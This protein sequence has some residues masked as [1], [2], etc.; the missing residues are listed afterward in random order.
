MD[1]FDEDYFLSPDEQYKRDR[2]DRLKR[3][4]EE[5]NE[6]RKQRQFLEIQSKKDVSALWEPK[7]EKTKDEKSYE[8]EDEDF[9]DNLDEF[10]DCDNIEDSFEDDFQSDNEK[11]EHVLEIEE[12]SNRKSLMEATDGLNQKHLTAILSFINREKEPKNIKRIMK[13]KYDPQNLKYMRPLFF[14]KLKPLF[15][16]REQRSNDYEDTQELKSIIDEIGIYKVDNDTITLNGA[17]NSSRYRNRSC[18][19]KYH[20]LPERQ[21]ERIKAFLDT[22]YNMSEISAVFHRLSYPEDYQFLLKADDVIPSFHPNSGNSSDLVV[23]V[24]E[25][26]YCEVDLNDFETWPLYDSDDVDIDVE[27]E[28]N[29]QKILNDLKE[30]IGKC[31]GLTRIDVGLSI[32]YSQISKASSFEIR[33]ID[34][35]IKLNYFPRVSVCIFKNHYPFIRFNRACASITYMVLKIV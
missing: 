17:V 28:V 4:E 21:S 22:T 2:Q 3:I 32:P 9:E 33:L 12:N 31:A 29:F 34:M 18:S 6:K 27:F 11:D 26:D 8:K 19:N 25:F 23:G 14:S 5:E 13:E 10:D 24:H 35:L 30:K 16:L 7:G 1:K 15:F 20:E